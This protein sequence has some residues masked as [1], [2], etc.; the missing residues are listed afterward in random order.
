ML[1]S[2]QQGTPR[3]RLAGNDFYRTHTYTQTH[4]QVTCSPRKKEAVGSSAH[5]AHQAVCILL[6]FTKEVGLILGSSAQPDLVLALVGLVLS[7]GLGLLLSW[8]MRGSWG[9]DTARSQVGTWVMPAFGGGGK[10]STAQCT[11]SSRLSQTEG[12]AISLGTLGDCKPNLWFWLSPASLLQQ[13]D[14]FNF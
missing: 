10:G 12:L 5:S 6:S 4:T 9:L 11:V 8:S 13:T 7:P 3:R 14:S 1:E 2:T